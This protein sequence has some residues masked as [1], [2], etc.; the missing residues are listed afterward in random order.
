[1]WKNLKSYLINTISTTP[2]WFPKCTD[3]ITAAIYIKS[4]GFFVVFL[5]WRT[6]RILFLLLKKSFPFLEIFC[7]S[8]LQNMKTAVQNFQLYDET[9]LLIQTKFVNWNF[10]YFKDTVS[11]HRPGF[12][13]HRFLDFMADKV[14]KK[15]P[16]RKYFII[17]RKS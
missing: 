2:T 15:I 11:V 13:A 16:S 5:A 12:Y 8:V 7:N 17:L 6:Y 10:L 1:M 14:F 4:Y 9:R 3:R